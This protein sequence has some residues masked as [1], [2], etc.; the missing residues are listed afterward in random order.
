M[1]KTLRTTK[2]LYNNWENQSQAVRKQF[3]F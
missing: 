1:Q 2:S 3:F